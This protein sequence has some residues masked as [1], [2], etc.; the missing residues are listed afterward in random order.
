MTVAE[1]TA[2]LSRDHFDEGY[3]DHIRT[4]EKVTPQKRI[5]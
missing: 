4:V 3:Q 5:T 2:L 1:L